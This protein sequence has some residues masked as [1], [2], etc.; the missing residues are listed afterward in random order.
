MS[1]PRLVRQIVTDPSFF[2]VSLAFLAG[3]AV[4]AGLGILGFLSILG[5]LAVQRLAVLPDVVIKW[6]TWQDK[7]PRLF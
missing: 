4:L 2:S 3:L 7:N 6:L 1:P 5:I